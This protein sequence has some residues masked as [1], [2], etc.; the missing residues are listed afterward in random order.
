M[1]HISGFN[2]HNI[3]R[4]TYQY[5]IMSFFFQFVFRSHFS[6]ASRMNW[7]WIWKRQCWLR[8]ERYRKQN[9][10]KLTKWTEYVRFIFVA[11]KLRRTM[12]MKRN[13]NAARHTDC[14]HNLHQSNR[15]SLRQRKKN[16]QETKHSMWR[17][18]FTI[19][20]FSLIPNSI[21]LHLFYFIV[22]LKWLKFKHAC[23]PINYYCVEIRSI[24]MD[25]YFKD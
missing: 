6:I 13:T 10:R 12:W 11:L 7:V 4:F 14:S 22:N 23:R 21:N 2:I 19:N 1:G 20:I 18:L 8:Y 24:F 25:L 15:W 3:A 17:T 5:S 16:N 9:S